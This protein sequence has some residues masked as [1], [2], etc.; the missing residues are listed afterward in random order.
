MKIK[1]EKP[2]LFILWNSLLILL[3]ASSLY[4]GKLIV[5]S[6]D[7]L[8][9]IFKFFIGLVGFFSALVGLFML[10][11]V[12]PFFGLS[13]PYDITFAAYGIG[14]AGKT[15]L[16]NQ[17]LHNTDGT[18]KRTKRIVIKSSP[19]V[20]DE[21]TF[22]IRTI[23][24]AGQNEGDF[25]VNYLMRGGR[26]KIDAYVLVFSFFPVRDEDPFST[27]LYIP[28]QIDEKKTVIRG[29]AIKQTKHFNE[30]VIKDLMEGANDLSR[31]YI[32]VNQMDLLFQNSLRERLE[33]AKSLFSD[34]KIEVD[35]ALKTYE[36]FIG[37]TSNVFYVSSKT[38]LIYNTEHC[39]DSETEPLKNMLN[40]IIEQ[41]I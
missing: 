16:I 25:R 3:I 5:A 38:G 27:D 4:H 32:V 29:L 6:W 34:I 22:Y 41:C 26:K 17:L 9:L 33:F 11:R 12:L 13:V 21:K 7:T 40:L 31:I 37:V 23:D 24:I 1:I 19:F 20:K 36:R 8:E 28:Q 30:A 18:A 14:G 10:D 15:S 39:S 2:R 35:N